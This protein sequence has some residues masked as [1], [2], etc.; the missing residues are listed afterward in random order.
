M[1]VLQ[2]LVHP[3]LPSLFLSIPL[4][5]LSLLPTF[6]VVALVHFLTR[7][8]YPLARTTAELIMTPGAVSNCLKMALD[9]FRTVNELQPDSIRAVSTFT[10][11]D[12]STR[13]GMIRSYWSKNDGW[14]PDWIKADV[15]KALRIHPFALPANVGHTLTRARSFSVS[16]S[17]KVLGALGLSRTPSSAVNG[18]AANGSPVAQKRTR[19]WHQM[20]TASARRA[21]DGSI[22]LDPPDDFSETDAEPVPFVLPASP[23]PESN[24]APVPTVGSG[25]ITSTVCE[26]GMPHAFCLHCESPVAVALR[27]H[28]LLT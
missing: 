26:L 16:Q 12:P 4:L 10:S 9:E 24:D 27:P 17:R 6:L 1:P 25:R 5:I 15:E 2:Y 18:N 23:S 11:R 7:Q 22:I 21:L 3:L 19:P 14:T 13:S 8:P 20:R 28:G